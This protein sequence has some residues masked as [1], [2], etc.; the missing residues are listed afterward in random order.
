MSRS[1]GTLPHKES[2]SVL[3][4]PLAC[5][6][7]KVGREGWREGGEGGM[8]LSIGRENEEQEEQEAEEAQ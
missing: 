3:S 8:F 2:Q 6:M 5:P 1:F 4:Y 7:I